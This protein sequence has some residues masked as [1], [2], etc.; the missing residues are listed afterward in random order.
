MFYL[1]AKRTFLF[2]EQNAHL[3][4]FYCLYLTILQLTQ[5][6]TLRKAQPM[7]KVSFRKSEI[8]KQIPFFINRCL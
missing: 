7:Y 3:N 2:S 4:H 8:L 5:E 1:R 6:E